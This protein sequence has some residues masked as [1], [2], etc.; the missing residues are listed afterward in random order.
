MRAEKVKQAWSDAYRR[1]AAVY[2]TSGITIAKVRQ[3][4]PAVA[5]A[6]EEAE[7]EAEKASVAWRDGGPGGVQ[8]KIDKWVS[9]WL[10]AIADGIG[11][12]A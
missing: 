8:V 3:Y 5:Q 7:V 10:E 12:A 9:L 1:V 4:A 2:D 11:A 6:I